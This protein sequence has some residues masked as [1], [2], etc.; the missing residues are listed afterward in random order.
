MP[1]R[2]MDDLR[3]EAQPQGGAG[4]GT[5]VSPTPNPFAGG[6]PAPQQGGNFTTAGGYTPVVDQATMGG[7]GSDSVFIDCCGETVPV[8]Q[9]S[10]WQAPIAMC[11]PCCIGDPCSSNRREW[12][13]AQM[14]TFIGIITIVQVIFFIIEVA[15]SGWVGVLD[16]PSD[17][18]AQMG[19]KVAPLIAAGEYWRL[20][21][22]IMLHAG[23]F[24][25]LVNCFVQCMFGIQL[26]REWKAPRIATIYLVAGIYGNVLS[27][28]FAPQALSIGCSGAIFG[29]FGA[30]VAYITGMWRLLG[31]LQKKMLMLSFSLSFLFIGLFSFSVG[32]DMSAHLGGFL[33]GMVMGMGYFA[34]QWPEGH[35]WNLYGAV[36]AFSTVGLTIFLSVIYMWHNTDLG[37]SDS[38]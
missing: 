24:H 31:D 15:L 32:V 2:T 19:G 9:L 33:A 38:Y 10:I 11:C 30:Q 12:Y 18:L 36:V 14:Q 7:V 29:L 21:T 8:N 37:Y 23:I 27:V 20:V 16:V 4:T 26:E 5:F 1:V 34:H 22:P 25:L 28:L 35:W 17:V 13:L 3:R 6:Q